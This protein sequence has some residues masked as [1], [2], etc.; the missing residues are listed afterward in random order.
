MQ[1]RS[2]NQKVPSKVIRGALL[3]YLQGR[4]GVNS[5]LKVKGCLAGRMLW[6]GSDVL[7]SA[8]VS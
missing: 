7:Q 8:E 4:L 5:L 3:A 1:M 2:P 6:D